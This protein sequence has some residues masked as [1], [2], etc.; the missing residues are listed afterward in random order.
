M[1]PRRSA[2]AEVEEQEHEDGSVKLQFNE[3]LTWRP[4]K[5]IPID[6]LLKRLDRLTKELAEMDQ[7]E[8][9]TSSLTKVA[10]EVA[11]HQLLNHKDKGV[12]A[13]TACCVVDI[14]R[15]CA[16]DAPFT[17]SQL[18]DVFNLTVTSIIPSLFDPSNPYNN[19]HK[20]VLRSLAEIKSVVLLLDVDGSE[21]LL[22]HLFSTIFDGVS[23]SKSASGEQVAKDV[24][25][26][27]QELL[28]VLVEDAAS[29]PPQ[30]LWM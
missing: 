12:R 25:Y 20:Y 18:K 30:R 11:S 5:P 15:L 6:T 10:K 8:T 13:Y 17:P 9:D 4:G 28:G 1:A 24:E 2:A 27:M 7:E 14:L 29:L 23:G 22:L 21:N 16:P 26:S 3:P 19:Q